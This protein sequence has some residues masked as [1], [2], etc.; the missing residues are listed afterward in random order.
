[1]PRGQYCTV[2]SRPALRCVYFYP[3][4]VT[5]ETAF[6][7]PCVQQHRRSL[8][9]KPQP[10]SVVI[11]RKL[12]TARSEANSKV[13]A[14]VKNYCSVL[15][16]VRWELPACVRLPGVHCKP[17]SEACR[18]SSL[19]LIFTAAMPACARACGVCAREREVKACPA[20]STAVNNAYLLPT[21]LASW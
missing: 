20:H 11:S 7:P 17:P 21:Q 12:I 2:I 15:V 4:K 18:A 9:H 13:Q 19:L 10:S 8:I 6:S 5:E 1:M 3:P 16:L 14:E